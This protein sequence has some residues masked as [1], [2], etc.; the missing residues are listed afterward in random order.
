MLLDPLA[1]TSCSAWS[2]VDEATAAGYVDRLASD[3]GDE[4]WDLRYGLRGGSR[5]VRD[6]WCPL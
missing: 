5:R 6:H 1:R 2:F 3:L 4:A